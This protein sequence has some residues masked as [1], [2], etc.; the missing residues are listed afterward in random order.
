MSTIFTKIINKEIPGHFLYEDDVCVA[1][2]DIFPTVKG[3]CLVIPKT[4]V[5]YAFDLDDETYT[6][7]F[8]IAKKLALALDKAFGNTRTCLVV[9]GFDVPHMHIKMYPLTDADKPL[10]AKI[11]LG[12]EADQ[13]ELKVVA[14]QI[15]TALED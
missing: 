5:D 3:Q 4:E 11:A 15:I 6:H 12:K 1:I 14:T 2:L 9:E 10:G 7:V 13:E 8:N